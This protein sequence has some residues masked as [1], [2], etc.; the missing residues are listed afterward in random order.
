MSTPHTLPAPDPSRDESALPEDVRQALL[1]HESDAASS[2]ADVANTALIARVKAKLLSGI[3]SGM[4]A[5]APERITSAANDG[6]WRAMLPGIMRKT[7]LRQG[8]DVSVLLRMEP[9]SVLPAHLHAADEHCVVISG[10]LRL[11]NSDVV[12]ESGGFHWV[13]QHSSHEAIVAESETLVYLRG[14]L[15]VH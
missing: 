11:G 1:A 12:I 14:A 13:A 6:R 7:L 3:Q 4:Q 10:R 5:S 8:D 2:A 9:G 15:D